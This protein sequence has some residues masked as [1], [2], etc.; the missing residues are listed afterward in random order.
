MEDQVPRDHP[1]RE[2]RVLVDTIQA[3]L[4]GVLTARYVVGWGQSGGC[5]QRCCRW[6]TYEVLYRRL[7]FGKDAQL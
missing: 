5:A 7:P 2:L 4:G 6:F 1:I 3:N